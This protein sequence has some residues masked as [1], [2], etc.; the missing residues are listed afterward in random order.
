MK[1]LSQSMRIISKAHKK[2]LEFWVSAYWIT[3]GDCI[4]KCEG[5]TQ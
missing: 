2:I 3:A 5:S 4:V 1:N